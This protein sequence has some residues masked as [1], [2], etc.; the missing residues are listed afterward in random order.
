MGLINSLRTYYR[1]RE[2][3]SSFLVRL[4]FLFFVIYNKSKSAILQMGY[5]SSNIANYF[6]KQGARIGDHCE[7]QV[8]SLG[9][10]P[11]LVNIGNH[12]LISKGVEFHTHDGGVWIFRDK[13]P[14][15]RVYGLITIGDNCIIGKDAQLLPNIRIGRNSIVGAGSVVISDIPPDSIV[16]G[17]PARVIS[18]VPKYEENCLTRWKEQKPSHLPL[19]AEYGWWLSKKNK[20]MLRKH[21][22]NLF[23]EQEKQK[24]E[25]ENKGDEFR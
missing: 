22:T 17:V 23:E 2:E 1:K 7:I 12:V 14:G 6:R 3:K 9:T 20:K 19:K 8:K 13:I 15:L 11:Y 5:S 21:L 4:L 24:R 25:A 10:E 16:M 18:S